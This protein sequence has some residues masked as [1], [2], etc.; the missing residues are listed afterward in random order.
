MDSVML[1]RIVAGVLNAI[2]GVLNRDLLKHQVRRI[3]ELS[4]RSQSVLLVQ[5]RDAEQV[6]QRQRR[7]RANRIDFFRRGL[8]HEMPQA[9]VCRRFC[10]LCG[11][12][13]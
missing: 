12:R 13:I 7:G 9:D 8:N 3:H 4:R 2:G 11:V 6:D 1:T 10:I 5:Y